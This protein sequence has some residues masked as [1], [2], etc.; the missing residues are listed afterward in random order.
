[1][2]LEGIM[3]GETSQ[4]WK[5][6]YCMIL[7]GS[8]KKLNSQEWNGEQIRGCQRWGLGV[9][10]TGERDQKAQT[11]SYKIHKFWGCNV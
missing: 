4:T 3:L 6:K 7:F 2:D 1:M 11:F 9:G 5:D 8:L 10:E